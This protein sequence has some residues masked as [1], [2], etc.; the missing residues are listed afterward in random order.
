MKITKRQLKRLIAEER[1]KLIKESRRG[2]SPM[3]SR[4]DPEFARLIKREAVD[5]V[6][7]P[8]VDELTMVTKDLISIL[9][10]IRDPMERN[11]EIYNIIDQLEDLA[12]RGDQ[13][14]WA[15]G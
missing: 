3:K 14:T 6:G 7:D 12:S 13:S 5:I 10:S 8:A 9:N 2:A 15:S 1:G 4:A 11:A